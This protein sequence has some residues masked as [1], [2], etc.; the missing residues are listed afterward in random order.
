MSRLI[1]FRTQRCKIFNR[2]GSYE[3]FKSKPHLSHLMRLWRFSPSVNSFFKRACAAIQ[4]GLISDSS[5]SILH[6][7]EQR[8]L[9]RVCANARRLAW[10]FSGRLCDKYH[11][12]IS[13]LTSCL[14]HFYWYHI[15]EQHFFQCKVKAIW[16]SSWEHLSSGFSTR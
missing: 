2:H 14:V 3:T 11:N 1:L 9:W 6:V 4:C 13:W 5:T 12:L 15:D 8:R 7:C 10:A 16:A